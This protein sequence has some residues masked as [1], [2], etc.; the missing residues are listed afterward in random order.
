MSVSWREQDN[1]LTC[2]F[3]GLG[4]RAC[5]DK[6]LTSEI[7]NPFGHFRRTPCAGDWPI[8]RRLSHYLTWASLNISQYP[9]NR[10]SL[11]IFEVLRA[12]KKHFEVFRV[13]APCSF[14]H[15]TIVSEDPTA[16]FFTL[17]RTWRNNLVAQQAAVHS[18][19][20]SFMFCFSEWPTSNL[21]NCCPQS[22][23]S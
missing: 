6:Q 5:S 13:I 1:R 11:E 4:P 23:G 20:V 16:S 18:I 3:N 21:A 2:T 12:V 8:A 9:K 15:D 17:K 19:W 7:V 22:L 14:F 10:G